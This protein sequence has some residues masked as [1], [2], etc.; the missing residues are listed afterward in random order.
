MAVE[1]TA[2]TTREEKKALMNAAANDPAKL[3]KLI[4]RSPYKPGNKQYNYSKILCE[5]IDERSD[6][7]DDPMLVA[8]IISRLLKLGAG[9]DECNEDGETLL[10]KASRSNNVTMVNTFLQRGANPR[11]VDSYGNTV[12]HY[13]AAKDCLDAIKCFKDISELNWEAI[14]ED[15][16]TA[17]H[18]AATEGSSKVTRFLIK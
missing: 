18:V 6:F 12:I 4:N 16:D 14:T 1:E 7:A 15:R 2:K 9:V 13:A 5:F 11:L 10:M 8:Q 17:L 3:I